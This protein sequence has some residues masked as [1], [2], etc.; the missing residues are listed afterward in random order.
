MQQNKKWIIV[1]WITQLL[2]HTMRWHIL[3]LCAPL[4]SPPPLPSKL[5]RGSFC[6]C[7]SFGSDISKCL[8]H[9][10]QNVIKPN[11]KK[12]YLFCGYSILSS[13]N[14]RSLEYE[15][16]QQ[17]KGWSAVCKCVCVVSALMTE[18]VM[19]IFKKG[20]HQLHLVFKLCGEYFLT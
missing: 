19:E 4:P 16:C 13:V 11:G 12:Q 6:L 2:G 18:S 7:H 20:V 15:C 1:Q 9:N 14:N 8:L 3:A 10:E 17:L 5:T